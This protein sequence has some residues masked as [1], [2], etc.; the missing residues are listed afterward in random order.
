MDLICID[1]TAGFTAVRDSQSN[2]AGSHLTRFDRIVQKLHAISGKLA[3]I[4]EIPPDNTVA[5]QAATAGK[6]HSAPLPFSKIP[7]DSTEID[8]T[9]GSHCHTTTS[10]IRSMTLNTILHDQRIFQNGTGA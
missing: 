5:E 7:C 2:A 3:C 8:R 10:Q 1:F 6:A 9:G 4:P